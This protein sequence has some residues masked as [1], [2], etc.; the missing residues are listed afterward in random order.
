MRRDP[1]ANHA[2]VGLPMYVEDEEGD[3]GK[4]PGREVRQTRGMR[5][6]P[7]YLQRVIAERQGLDPNALPNEEE[8]EDEDEGEE[9][10][11]REV[12]ASCA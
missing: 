6:P 10:G 1:G 4:P 3:V 7:E 11:G 12:P 9:G 2:A 8:D 5:V